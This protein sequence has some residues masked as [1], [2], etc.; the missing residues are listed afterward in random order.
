MDAF[1]S[2]A[3]VAAIVCVG[4]IVFFCIGT[5]AGMPARWESG[6]STVGSSVTLIMV[7]AIQH[8]QKREQ[9]V[10]QL[11]LDELLAALPTADDRVVKVEA[12]PDSEL[13]ELHER[14]LQHREAL[15]ESN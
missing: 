9:A 4:V 6:F 3:G 13:H 2:R 8:T 10:T 1:S 14:H 7:F 12:G 5:A 15:R 11:K